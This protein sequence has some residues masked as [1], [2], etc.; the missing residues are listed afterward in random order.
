MRD[1]IFIS[2]EEDYNMDIQNSLAQRARGKKPSPI[3]ELLKYM[4]IPG[5]ISLGGGYPNPETFVFDSVSIK[6][7]DGNEVSIKDSDINVASQY[8]PSDAHP[9][10]K[11]EI[12][13]WQE[14][15][16]GVSLNDSQIVIL[17]GSQEGLFI[18]SYLFLESNDSIVVSEPTY[19]GALSAFRSFTHNF[20]A[21][22]LDSNG[23]N[24]AI[25]EE[26][27]GDLKSKNQKLPK[28]I[29]II[30]NGHNPGGI[31]MSDERKEHVIKLANKYDL[32]IVE[33]D[34]YQLVK[35]E[36]KKNAATLQ[37]MDKQGRVIRLD[38]FS[39]IFAPG[40]RVG[41]AS[42]DSEIIRQFILFKQ[43]CNLH[44]S[45][46]IQE[47]LYQYMNA[48]GQANF[49][50]HIKN[51]CKLYQTNRDAMIDAAK[52]YLP[53]EVKFNIPQEGMFVWFELPEYMNAQQ[54]VDK[55]CEK[56]KVLL[57][58]GI[59]FS[60]IKGNKNCMRASFSLVP[61]D[62]IHEGIKRFGEM[63]QLELT[64]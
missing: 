50:N 13:K 6:F 32:L 9:K 16:D 14:L 11:N 5:M 4:K 40:L 52:K 44:T 2:N 42:G 59:S 36:S 56:L 37:S 29:Y 38:S 20:I 46:F 63:I 23:M 19:P 8:G 62:Q 3:R 15:K 17:N 45:M 33:D 12:I 35:L 54:L 26:K 28:I 60:T 41:Y 31:S 61:P 47:I 39:K 53:A 24:T 30:P 21:I 43:S 55:Y 64:S 25:L 10:L 51:N 1:I 57:V 34:P 48:F 49:L 22:P 18:V 27:L 7:K 58:P